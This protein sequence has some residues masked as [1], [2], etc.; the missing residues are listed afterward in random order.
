MR[1][2]RF[3]IGAAWRA[4]QLLLPLEMPAHPAAPPGRGTAQAPQAPRVPP[5]PPSAADAARPSRDSH[6]DDRRAPADLPPRTDAAADWDTRP[7]AV[8]VGPHLRVVSAAASRRGVRDGMT[9]TVARARCAELVVLAW[10]ELAI[11]AEV[12]RVSAACVAASPQ[13]TP[14]RGAPGLWWIG[15]SGF[16][17]LGGERALAA[18]LL[19]IARPWHVEAR[20]AIADS[21]VAARAGTWDARVPVGAHGMRGPVLVPTGHDAEYLADV[22]LALLP[23]PASLRASLAALGFATGAG[24]AAL[25]PADVE[26]R[27]GAEGLTAWRLARGED[28]RRPFL[29]RHDAPRTVHTEL[30]GPAETTEPL[31]FLVR[32]ALERLVAQ[33]VADARAVAAVTLTLT[34]DDARGAAPDAGAR[35]HTVTREARPAE[36]VARVG[37]LFEQ[38]RALLAGWPLPAPVT[39]VT[40]A[41]TATAPLAGRQG[42]LLDASWRDLAAVEAALARLRAELGAGSVVIPA[43]VDAHLPEQAGAWLEADAGEAALRAIAAPPPAAAPP[44]AT[45]ATLGQTPGATGR[46][47]LDAPPRAMRLL[48]PAEPAEVDTDGRRPTLL[49]WRSRRIRLV[50]VH[51]PERLDGQWWQAPVARDYWR[52]ADSEQRE[53]VVYSDR[54]AGRW[55]VHGWVD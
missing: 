16:D 18:Q 34:L 7:V 25:D 49:R 21:C 10:D 26:Q 20:V 32:A 19:A 46:D 2:P 23:M 5:A 43:A 42:D 24:F 44:G 17:G 30:G 54:A 29:P 33:G 11:R 38:C 48:E 40:V 27:W 1:I 52:C 41:I 31:L 6:G 22:P 35:A 51:G 50:H 15:A 9:V 39:A 14:V 53:Y 13:V 45:V 3:P 47:R 36:P 4:G 8:R 28:P 37:P 12:A 55:Y